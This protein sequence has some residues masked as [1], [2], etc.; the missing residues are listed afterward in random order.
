MPDARNV[1]QVAKRTTGFVERAKAE[2]KRFEMV[3]DTN[4]YA[5]MCFETKEQ[6]DEFFAALVQRGMPAPKHGNRYVDGLAVAASMGM[7]IKSPRIAWPKRRETRA[8]DVQESDEREP[9]GRPA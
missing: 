5:V 6:R 7:E 9:P 4:Y 1:T 2:Q 8:P 3:T